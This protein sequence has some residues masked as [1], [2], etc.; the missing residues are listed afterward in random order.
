MIGIEITDMDPE[1]RKRL[2][3]LLSRVPQLKQREWRTSW[4]TVSLD[5]LIDIDQI[6]RNN[7]P[8]IDLLH[9][10]D[11]LDGLTLQDGRLA[12]CVL[13]EDLPEIVDLEHVTLGDDI[14]A[15]TREMCGN[16]TVRQPGVAERRVDYE[17]TA[18]P[19]SDQP[20]GAG[21]G[22][23]TRPKPLRPAYSTADLRQ[24]L[25]RFDDVGIDK[26]CLD[27]F[28]EVYDQFSRGMRRDEKIN[29][30]L[31]H[32]RRHSGAYARLV[33]LLGL[34]VEDVALSEDGVRGFEKVNP[35][36]EIWLELHSFRYDPFAHEDGG[37][38]EQLQHYFWVFPDYYAIQ[39]EL[40]EMST[41]LVFGNEGCGKSSLVNVITH[42]LRQLNELVVLYNDFSLLVEQETPVQIHDH[43]DHILVL[44]LDVL[45]R[46]LIEEDVWVERA[47]SGRRHVAQDCLWPYVRRYMEPLARQDVIDHLGLDEHSQEPLPDRPRDQLRFLMRYIR[48]LTGYQKLHIVVDP[49]DDI[50]PNDV[51][52][53]WE[54]L[55]PL[56]QA[57]A[58]VEQPVEGVGFGFFLNTDFAELC[59]RIPW[60]NR[61]QIRRVFYL[62]GWT[63]EM[64]ADLLEE[65]LTQ[66]SDRSPSYKDL[67]QLSKIVDGFDLDQMVLDRCRRPRE[68]I[69]LCNRL[70]DYHCRRPETASQP[71]ITQ[72]EALAVLGESTSSAPNPLRALI[73]SGEGR[74]V[75]FK[76]TLQINTF[77]GTTDK[78]LKEEIALTIAAFMNTEGGTLLVGVNDDGQVVGLE[79]DMDVVRNKNRDGFELAF[80]Y[81]VRDYLGEAHHPQLETYFAEVDGE[82]V[83]VVEVPR[84]QSPVFCGKSNDFYVRSGNQSPKLDPQQ[85]MTYWSERFPQS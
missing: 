4:L 28:P 80:G 12:L 72:E 20:G 47:E 82:A 13:L 44:V 68:L 64:L 9:I 38:D 16:G 21:E 71:Y 83:F 76:E 26:V 19:L 23:G 2:L 59:L 74:K 49:M 60:I 29:N 8:Y 42:H 54:I 52:A 3:N 34:T 50:V 55:A 14:K 85:M 31:D 77:T 58:V 37:S 75:E 46:A 56:L 66:S 53:A 15:L 5:G 81:I 78:R 69:V 1:L 51:N 43:M 36:R 35:Y 11:H 33:E 41:I 48:A 62:P 24:H 57:H 73:Q 70:V 17:T 65:R 18:S 10:L 22:V 63:R 6:D 32:C 27:Y 84:G 7:L 39:R 79:P 30:L 25:A 40:S 45:R 61:E 67:K